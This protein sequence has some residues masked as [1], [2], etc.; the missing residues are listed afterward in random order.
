MLSEENEVVN[1][2]RPD[3]TNLGTFRQLRAIEPAQ[4][5]NRKEMTVLLQLP[6]ANPNPNLF[7]PRHRSSKTK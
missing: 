6:W 7:P 3:K 4:P 5:T 2:C 1:S